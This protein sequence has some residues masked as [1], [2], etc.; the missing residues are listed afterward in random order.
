[1]TFVSAY[2]EAFGH[3]RRRPETTTVATP[4]GDTAV[5]LLPATEQGPAEGAETVVLLHGG[6]A[7]SAVWARLAPAL[8]NHRAVIA[9]DVVGDLGASVPSDRRMN[10]AT[11][12]VAWLDAVLAQVGRGPVILL[13]H[14]YGAWL[15]TTY[16]LARPARLAGLVLLDPTAVV[17]MQSL[18]V[19]LR[20]APELLGWV[21]ATPE[22]ARATIERE[23]GGAQVPGW[24]LDLVGAAATQP[25]RYA[26]TKP[27]G[28]K[29]LAG[30]QSRIHDAG[31]VARRCRVWLPRVEVVTVPTATHFSL[32]FDGEVARAVR[33]WPR[34]AWQ[35]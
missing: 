30:G 25:R 21:R 23:L 13:G 16:A 3:W 29:A 5:Y 26:A 14:S 6:G 32:P 35:R 34:G 20:A 12:V 2:D 10:S 33:E 11:D 22:R 31:K 9:V 15:A 19:L 18:G 28:R 4:Y 24:W 1:M 8:A 17:A 7:T 27:P